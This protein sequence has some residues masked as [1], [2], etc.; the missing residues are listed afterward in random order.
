MGDIMTATIRLAAGALALLAAPSSWSTGSAEAGAALAGTC[1][2]CH[3]VNGNSTNGE[4]P[5]LAGQNAAYLERQLHLLHDGR[6]TG[7]AGDAGAAMMPAMATSLTD[8][9]IEDV[10]AYYAQQVPTGLEADPSYWQAGQK[11]YRSGDRA[12]GIPACAAC[13]GPTGRGNPAAGYPSLRAQQSMYVIKQ[14]SAYSADVRYSKDEKGASSGGDNAVIMHTIAAR[15]T[16]EDMRNIA[17][18]I[19]GM[20]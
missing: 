16:D 8:Q 2:A 11:L 12:R 14:L 5:S 20:R 3:G 13:H 18:Y 9:N 10:A 19:Q 1:L 6:R 4:W 7:K 15:L 17:S